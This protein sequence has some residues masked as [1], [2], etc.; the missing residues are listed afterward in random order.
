MQ[1]INLFGYQPS[2]SFTIIEEVFSV[3]AV[4]ICR[5]HVNLGPKTADGRFFLRYVDGK[6]TTQPIGAYT[7][8][9]T[10][11]K[12]ASWTPLIQKVGSE[13]ATWGLILESRERNSQENG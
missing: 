1:R 2:P 12:V 5:K 11:S 6:C 13:S 8:S 4:E 7:I 10:F 3:N 9:K